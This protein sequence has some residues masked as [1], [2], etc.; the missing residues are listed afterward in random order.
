[1]SR[2]F[3]IG[4]DGSI[5]WNVSGIP[6]ASST[7][8]RL[9]FGAISL[10]GRVHPF[11]LDSWDP[12]LGVELGMAREGALGSNNGSARDGPL[13]TIGI[14]ADVYATRW[15][16]VGAEI[17]TLVLAFPGDVAVDFTSTEYATFRGTG[18]GLIF[19]VNATF[20]PRF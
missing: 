9:R 19:G 6:D 3:S 7:L 4:L 12:W 13:A 16:A 8:P 20:R 14:G 2:L 15:F 5:V 18:L 17:R 1:V 10:E 11:D